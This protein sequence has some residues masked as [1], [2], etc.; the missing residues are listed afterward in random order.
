MFHSHTNV[1]I[2]HAH[3]NT[4]Y[5]GSDWLLC[6]LCIHS[7]SLSELVHV[8]TVYLMIAMNYRYM[9]LV[10]IHCYMRMCLYCVFS[11]ACVCV[12]VCGGG[13]KLV[14]SYDKINA[15]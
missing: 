9:V 6:P 14:V 1:V 15:A 13:S 2:Y 11:V 3:K 8:C 10:V 7:Q 5:T 12:C 4:E